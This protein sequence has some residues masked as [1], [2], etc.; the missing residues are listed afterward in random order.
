MTLVVVVPRPRPPS[1]LVCR[2]QVTDGRAPRAGQHVRGP[3]GQ[4]GIHPEAE[5]RHGHQGDQGREGGGE[6]DGEE[7]RRQKQRVTSYLLA[8]R[9]NAT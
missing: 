1:F 9:V 8:D 7:D 5:V 6:S 3:E 4:H 2:H